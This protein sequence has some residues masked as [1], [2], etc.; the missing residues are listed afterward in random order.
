MKRAVECRIMPE[1]DSNDGVNY[2]S[3]IFAKFAL[4][5][6]ALLRS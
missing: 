4:E 2:M 6:V 5:N 3:E 1:R